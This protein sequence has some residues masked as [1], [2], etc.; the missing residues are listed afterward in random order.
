MIK[1]II[2][3]IG[4]RYILTRGSRAY[5]YFCEKNTIGRQRMKAIEG[6]DRRQDAA[7]EV[8]PATGEGGPDQGG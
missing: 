7:E 5:H 8:S 6:L 4:E 2:R 3:V 1:Q